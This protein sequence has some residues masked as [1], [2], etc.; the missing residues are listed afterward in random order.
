MAILYKLIGQNISGLSVGPIS[1]KS[2]PSYPLGFGSCVCVKWKTFADQTETKMDTNN[3]FIIQCNTL[4]Y[5][6]CSLDVLQ[7]LPLTKI[8][9]TFISQPVESENLI[10]S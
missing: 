1:I 9:I 10:R 3:H 4:F 8:K 5:R 7:A 6:L 2:N